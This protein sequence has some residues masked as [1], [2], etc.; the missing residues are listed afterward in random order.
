[1]TEIKLTR[2]LAAFVAGPG[3]DTVP[4]D[5]LPTIRNGFIDTLAC[6]LS[7]RKE[8]VTRAARQVASQRG[9]TP[10]AGVL[11]GQERLSAP[12]AAFVN[13]VS[14]HALDYDDMALNGHPSVVL[15]PALLA[16]GEAG[17]VRDVELMRAYLV[18][19][20]TWAEL[21]GLSCRLHDTWAQIPAF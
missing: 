18:G 9:S 15:V 13:A 8:P 20:E 10:E 16:A 11:L 7:G 21:V 12:D 6:L 14:A 4:E 19:Y 5:V 17:A 2:G 3:F 1:M